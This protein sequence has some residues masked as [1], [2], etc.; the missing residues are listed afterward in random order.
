M[1]K[2]VL[3]ILSFSLIGCSNTT[4]HAMTGNKTQA[5]LIERTFQ[6]AMEYNADG[7]ATYWQDPN[8]QKSG[9]IKPLYASYDWTPP[10][11]HFEIA[12]FYPNKQPTYHY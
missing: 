4:Y 5:D 7:V 10:C 6:H 9:A 11:R 12:Y 1:G 3:I 2:L 8:S